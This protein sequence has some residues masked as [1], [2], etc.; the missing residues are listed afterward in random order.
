MSQHVAKPNGTSCRGRAVGLG[1][2]RTLE[3]SNADR[4]GVSRQ[5]DRPIERIAYGPA[6]AAEALGIGVTTLRELIARHEI[7][8]FRLG[9]RVLIRK[10]DLQIFADRLFVEQ[11]GGEI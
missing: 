9:R 2:T 5:T 3:H 7:K 8:T 10:S 11:N 1:V 4:H 6:E